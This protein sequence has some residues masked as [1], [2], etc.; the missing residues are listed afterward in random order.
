MP[1]SVEEKLQRE[2]Y[3]S[4][5]QFRDDVRLVFADCRDNNNPGVQLS[6][7]FARSVVHVDP[8]ASH[9]ITNIV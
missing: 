9:V 3:D 2:E 7:G 6:C 1:F 4:P 5:L 8:T